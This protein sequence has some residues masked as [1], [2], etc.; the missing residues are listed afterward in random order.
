M[1][2]PELGKILSDKTHGIP[3]WCEE[4]VEN[5]VQNGL[6]QVSQS[7]S[8]EL[9]LNDTKITE[10]TEPALND[11]KEESLTKDL[12][13]DNN[14]IKPNKKRGGIVRFARSI[15]PE[16]ISVP[17]TVTGM[18]LA[19]FDNLSPDSQLQLKC[20]SVLGNVFSR[21][22]LDAIVPDNLNEVAFKKGLDDLASFG[23]IACSHATHSGQTDQEEEGEGSN[24][25]SCM[26]VTHTKKQ[27]LSHGAGLH[28]KICTDWCTMFEFVHPY[29]RETVYGLWTNSQ[30]RDLHEKAALFLES[31]A[32]KCESC[33]GGGF[34]MLGDQKSTKEK[35]Q[36]TSTKGRAF[37][38]T[39]TRP[40]TRRAS[41]AGRRRNSVAPMMMYESSSHESS[42]FSL[43]QAVMESNKRQSL[44]GSLL[45]DSSALIDCNLQDCHCDDILVKVYP[46]LIRHWKEVGCDERVLHYL[47][48]AGA[49]AVSTFNNLEAYSLLQ[50]AHEIAK[51]KEMAGV[52][53][54]HE[55][56]ELESLIGQVCCLATLQVQVMICCDFCSYRHCFR[57]EKLERA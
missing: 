36:A 4:L 17:D 21:A 42:M 31:Q 12:V 46:Q 53:S 51:R 16:D 26:C 47:I 11:F 7:E 20:A 18:I 48:E 3:L 29:V 56:A 43:Q 24:E 34:A 10:D 54:Q 13:T 23:L 6:L 14:A 40:R 19:R 57:V 55:E 1:I 2:P 27:S 9:R 37:V 5:M 49:A 28:P 44:V 50:E 45:E 52:L 30:R 25:P 38:G 22:M 32:H 33:G 39:V 41:I 8:V 35:K 15:R